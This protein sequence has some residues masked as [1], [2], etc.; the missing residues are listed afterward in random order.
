VPLVKMPSVAVSVSLSPGTMPGKVVVVA[1]DIA[2][3]GAAGCS[4]EELPG[5]ALWVAVMA[6]LSTYPKKLRG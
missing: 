1:A 4:S 6:A 5:R 3:G 2:V